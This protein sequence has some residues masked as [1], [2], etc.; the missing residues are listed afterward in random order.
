MQINHYSRASGK[1]RVSAF[2]NLLLGF[3]CCLLFLLLLLAPQVG[4]DGAH[5]GL[6]LCG[7]VIVPSLFPFLVLSVFVIDTGLAQRFGRLL[8]RPVRK[9]FRLPGSAAAALA[10]GLIGGYPVGAKACAELCSK[11]ALSRKEANRLLAFCINS[12]PAFIIGAVGAGLLGSAAAGILLYIAHLLASLIIGLASRY[13]GA[14]APE[15]SASRSIRGESVPSALVGSVTSSAVSIINICAFV[16]TFSALSALLTGVPTLLGQPPF[17]KGA[18]AGILKGF[19]EV[20]NGCAAAAG[21]GGLGGILTITLFLSWSG[22]SVIFQ[23]IYAVRS[24]GLSVKYYV[25]CRL[26]H[27]LLAGGLTLLLFRLFPVSIPAFASGAQRLQAGCHSAPATAA[28]L[29]V[30]SLLLLSQVKV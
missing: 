5:T 17:D 25:L 30:C 9:L 21:F 6:L 24:A 23:I 4:L 8:E 18:A 11:G 19:L 13:F 2:A 26:P 10:L 7:E 28:L 20:S 16:I 27:M 3:V 22:L 14:R 12:S 15:T 29:I 1:K